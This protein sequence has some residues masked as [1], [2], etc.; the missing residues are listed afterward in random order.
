ME[1]Q[2]RVKLSSRC[3]R[4]SEDNGSFWKQLEVLWWCVCVHGRRHVALK[5]LPFWLS[6]EPQNHNEM[7]RIYNKNLPFQNEKLQ[8]HHYKLQ[9]YYKKLESEILAKFPEFDMKN[10]VYQLLPGWERGWSHTWRQ[11]AGISSGRRSR[12]PAAQRQSRRRRVHRFWAVWRGRRFRQ[13]SSPPAG[14]PRC[15]WQRHWCSVT[16]QQRPNIFEGR[17]SKGFSELKLFISAIRGTHLNE[18]KLKEMK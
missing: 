17:L 3:L 7:F 8:F 10:C 1:V 18:I 12:T 4:S 14:S 6:A 11:A 13:R 2:R 9:F 16:K 5:L 15:P